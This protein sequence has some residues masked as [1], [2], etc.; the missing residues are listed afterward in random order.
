MYLFRL[1]IDTTK[2]LRSKFKKHLGLGFCLE[3]LVGVV[4][5]S[6]VPL[7]LNWLNHIFQQIKHFYFSSIKEAFM[8]QEWVVVLTSVK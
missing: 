1:H 8:S 3:S 2:K 7:L 4:V 6:Q 5:Q